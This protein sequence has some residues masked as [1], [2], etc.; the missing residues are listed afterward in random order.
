[1]N[2]HSD[3]Q[4]D[5]EA[6]RNRIIGL[7]ETSF[8]KSY[9]PELQQRIRDLEKKN[10]ELAQAYANQT[11]IEE[12]LR[13]QVDETLK[14]ERDLRES[15]EFLSGIVENL[16]LMIFVKSASDLRF[17][18][19]NKAGED[20][21]GYERSSLIGKNDHDFF[22]RDQA[23][24]FTRK[25]RQ[26]L[27]DKRAVDIP[28]ETITTRLLGERILHTR[29]IPIVSSSGNPRYL[30]GISEDITER[31]KSETALRDSEERYRTLVDITE[32]G[33]L[34]LD[35]KGFVI[36]A[37]E[38]YI[39]LTGRKSLDDLV[40]R[41][42]SEWTAPH[43][44]ERNRRAVEAC[45]STGYV[46][47][48]EIDYIHPDGTLQPVE[49]NATV[50]HSESGDV[51]LTLCRDISER[52]RIHVSLQQA[53]NKLTLLNAVTFQDIQTAAFSLAAYQEL[54]KNAAV[55]PKVQKYLD[56]QQVFLKKIVDTLEFARNYQDMGIHPPRWQNIRQVFL[57]A[58]SHL[59]FLN[60]RQ[61][62]HVDNL[63]VFADPLLE[64]V[65][66]NIMQNVIGHGVH[67][68]AVRLAYAEGNE[69]LRLTI[70]DNGVGIPTEEKNM[71]FDRGYGK[72]S[73]LG[74]F[75]VREVLSITGM[76]ISENGTPGQGTRF[77][78]TVPHGAYRF[79][80]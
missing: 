46:R 66:T 29:K 9:F 69:G 19:F 34:V 45:L 39:Q 16:P 64:K 72:G 44:Q 10:R 49:I 59:D 67:A 17:V 37:N 20:L 56:K 12:E 58:I 74:L 57:F 5:W 62:L 47:G 35:M 26:V 53:R 6:Q 76:T 4:P 43:D 63:E 55:D 18:R 42:V 75:L 1:M 3:E 61:D 22:P 14:K 51:V 31:K 33:Y 36:D 2:E 77:V 40:G 54:A 60:I 28:E 23:D 73:G 50:F 15:E 11:A 41:P 48:L 80:P 65:L 8:R 52:R 79:A 71:I 68:T 32:T 27:A 78:I 38:V 30:L 21:L 13:Q 24:F 70:E 7:G 25:D